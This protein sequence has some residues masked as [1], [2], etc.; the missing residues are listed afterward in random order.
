M[1]V[2]LVHFDVCGHVMIKYFSGAQYSI[3]FIDDY[4]IKLRVYA[5]KRKY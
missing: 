5:L 1:L 2:Q 4:S 3:T